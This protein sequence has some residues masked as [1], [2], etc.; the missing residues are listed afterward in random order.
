MAG[1]VVL[2]ARLF[3][4]Q[5]FEKFCE[6]RQLSVC[7]ASVNF[8][9]HSQHRPRFLVRPTSWRYLGPHPTPTPR[10]A[11]FINDSEY[12]ILVGA[13]GLEPTTPGFGGRYSIQMSYA[14]FS[15]AK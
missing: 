11:T 3:R 6:D 4:V 5:E 1:D 2:D 9:E 10:R 14:P 12:L 13:A 8:Q 15:M 7:E